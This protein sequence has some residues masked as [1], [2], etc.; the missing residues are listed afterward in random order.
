MGN[1]YQHFVGFGTVNNS[2]DV[3]VLISP[4]APSVQGLRI[5][6]SRGG[7]Q[8]ADLFSIENSAG[9][10]VFGVD[11][12]GNLSISVM[13]TGDVDIGG[14]LTV[15]GSTTLGSTLSVTGNS[16][17]ARVDATTLTAGT[18]RSG[19]GTVLVGLTQLSSAGEFGGAIRAATTLDVTGNAT[20]LSAGSFG[21]NV[22]IGTTLPLG[23]LQI[24]DSISTGIK[25]YTGDG[26]DGL[27]LHSQQSNDAGGGYA[28]YADI[29]SL[30]GQDGTNGGG[31]IRFLTNPANSDVVS[32]WVRITN[33]G[34][35]G[36][37]TTSP[38]GQLSQGLTNGQQIS[39]KSL[40]ELTTIAAAAT[41]D[42]TIQIPANVIVKAV[43]VRVT[44]AIP[45]ATTFTVIGTTTSTAFNT[46]AVSVDVNTTNKGNL[47]CP[48][49]NGAAQSIR[50]TPNQ[51][52]ADNSGRVRVTVWYE[53]SIPA[54]S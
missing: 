48:Y 29:V 17:F 53:D 45:T 50:I 25:T 15:T 33:T 39:Y 11:A 21:S 19:G 46:A 44:V 24:I 1:Y 4:R 18:L 6:P 3:Q 52:P 23:R 26:G 43:S 35:V 36:I 32:E 28:R 27:I 9:T 14:S 38:D 20:F 12:D 40:T 16:T 7:T 37:G 34:N 42:T 31:V 47:N 10:Q 5:V 54:T 41:T 51:T 22:G 49:N 13:L 30:G 8:I 2:A